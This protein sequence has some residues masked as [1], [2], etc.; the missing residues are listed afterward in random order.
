M[1]ALGIIF[2]SKLKWND[3]VAKAISKSNTAL[4]CIRLIKY[5]FTPDELLNIITGY[6]Y[7]AMYYRSEI[8][9][10]PNLNKDLGRK[11]LSTS[12]QA[13]KLCTPSYHDRMS[14]V[15]LHRINSRATPTQ[16]CDYKHALQLYKL[17]SLETPKVNWVDLNFQQ[18][19]SGR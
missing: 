11:L 3:H 18:V 13:L 17:T 12:A 8:W 14:F 2:D 16:M 19:F 4:H 5:Y 10:I 7:S 1:N 6:F 15:E 9:N